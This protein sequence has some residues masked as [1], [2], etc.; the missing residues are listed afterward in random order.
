MQPARRR[1]AP[2]LRRLLS[3]ARSKRGSLVPRRRTRSHRRSH[4]R[5]Q[6]HGHVAEH[7]S[8]L[9]R[10]SSTRISKTATY[11]FEQP[12][13]YGLVSSLVS[14][15]PL[16]LIAVVV[17]LYPAPGAERRK[18]SAFVRPL[19]R[20]DAQR[21]PAE[22][23]VRRRRGRR[24]SQRRAGEIVDFLK[25]PKKYQALGARIPKGVLLLGPPGSG[26]TLL[27]ARDRGRSRRAVLLDLRFR[28][29]RDVRRRRRVARA[30]SLRSSQEIRAVHRVHRRN[31]RGRPPARRRPRRRSRRARTNAQPAA[32]RDGRIRSE[33][34]R[35]PDRRDEPPRRARSGAAASGPFRPPDRRRSRRLQRPREDPR[36]ARAQQAARPKK[37]RSR[38][39]QSARP[40]FPAPISRTCSTK[41]RCS[42]RAATRTSSR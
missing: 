11:G 24:R 36:S 6:V 10:R 30:R 23:D 31:R 42:P 17:L 1:A 12:T 13:N 27:G 28:F 3:E 14:I 18:P 25:Y 8:A 7:R 16:L 26:K 35:H 15:A 39:S 2:R 19:A 33:H 41:P 29:R 34:R 5:D 40:D 20:E 9:R 4:H 22:G 38:R 21:E 32:R 37:S